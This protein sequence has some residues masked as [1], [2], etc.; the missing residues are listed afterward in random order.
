MESGFQ[1]NR[2]TVRDGRRDEEPVTDLE[3]H[4]SQ[5]GFRLSKVGSSCSGHTWGPEQEEKGGQALGFS[6]R[7]SE[8]GELWWSWDC[9]TGNPYHLRAQSQGLRDQGLSHTCSTTDPHPSPVWWA[10]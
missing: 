8:S 6:H 1:K 7:W 2:S 3:G 5:R 9:L 10:I 4:S